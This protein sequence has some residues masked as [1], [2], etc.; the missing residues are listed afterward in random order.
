MFKEGQSHT[1]ISLWG[2]YITE[3][4]WTLLCPHF[5]EEK[6]EEQGKEGNACFKILGLNVTAT[7][8]QLSRH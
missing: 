2:R 3:Y 7:I 8:L 6:E 5:L 1:R 4:D